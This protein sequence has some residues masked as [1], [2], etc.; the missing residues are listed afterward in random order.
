M[1]YLKQSDAFIRGRD[2]LHLVQGLALE[3]GMVDVFD[4]LRDRIPICTWIGENINTIN[5]QINTY[6]GL[7]HECFHPQERRHIQIFAVPIAQS[8]GIDGLC[9]ILINPI[10]IL[11]DVGRVAPRDWFGVV[12]HEY[13]HAHLGDFGHNEQFANILSHLCLG[14]G[15]EP[16]YWE[17]GM[18]ATLRS[19]PHCKST[20]DPLEFWIGQGS[21]EIGRMRK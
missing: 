2:Y 19:W 15:L 8:F 4:N 18:E 6:L 1:N 7:C 17:A 12:V 13:A 11:V 16:P 3:P 10:T 14:L 21:R 9:N 5:A 20:I